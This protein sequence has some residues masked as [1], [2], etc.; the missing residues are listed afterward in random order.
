MKNSERF[1]YFGKV[2]HINLSDKQTWIEE[3]DEVF[4]RRYAGG[5]CWL[6]TIF[7]GRHRR[8]LTF[9]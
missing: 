2:L 4:W 7:I 6:D 9:K 5:A 3:P 8:K 1:G